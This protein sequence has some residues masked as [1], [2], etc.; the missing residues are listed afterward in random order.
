MKLLGLLLIYNG[1]N[2]CKP[3]GKGRLEDVKG[4]LSGIHVFCHCF[5]HIYNKEHISLLSFFQEREQI[6]HLSLFK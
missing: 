3:P 5:V 6:I 1:K 4:N 2:H